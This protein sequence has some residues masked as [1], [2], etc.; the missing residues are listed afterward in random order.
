LSPV[1]HA[2]SVTLDWK[3]NTE[4]DLAGYRLFYGEG[5]RDY[6]TILETGLDT[7]LTVAG[8]S[9]GTTYYFSL[10]AY[11]SSGN[12]S[13]FSQEISHT[14]EGSDEELS[15]VTPNGGESLISGAPFDIQWEADTS[16]VKVR[17]WL[18][19]DAGTTWELV[20]GNTDNDG[21]WVCTVPEVYSTSCLL[22][23]E[24]YLNPDCFDVSSDYFTIGLSSG[25]DGDAP[26]GLPRTV[27][28]DQNYPNPFNPV[29]TISFQ[30]P[31]GEGSDP[32]QPVSLTV[33]DARGRKVRNLISGSLP[34]GTHK[35]AWDGRTERGEIA[36]SGIYFYSLRV[37][38]EILAPRK[39]TLAR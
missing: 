2:E 10:K 8:L 27:A 11:D 30:I 22:R 15:L 31:A 20:K 34:A 21:S 13:Q 6:S 14:V 38:A 28:L 33:Y 23:L 24:E 1:L 37:G 39:M 36:P 17:I 26:G 19:T 16:I 35:V 12:L 32:S 5:S 4:A 25:V 29:T 9:P 18:T 7:T 3:A